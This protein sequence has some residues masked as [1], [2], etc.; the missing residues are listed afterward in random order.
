VVTGNVFDNDTDPDGHV[1][2]VANPITS[3]GTNGTLVLNED[4]SYTYTPKGSFDGSSTYNY[5]VTDRHGS[6]VAA[7]LVIHL[8]Q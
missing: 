5:A 3:D 8:S 7:Q 1:L 6:T 4:G 2:F